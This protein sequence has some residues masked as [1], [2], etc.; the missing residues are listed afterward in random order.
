MLSSC[1]KRLVKSQNQCSLWPLLRM[2]ERMKFL[3][4]YINYIYIVFTYISC[5]FYFAFYCFTSKAMV[6]LDYWSFSFP[7]DPSKETWKRTWHWNCWNHQERATVT[8]MAHVRM[9][10]IH[11]FSICPNAVQVFAYAANFEVSYLAKNSGISK[12]MI[13]FFWMSNWKI[14]RFIFSS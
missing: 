2:V 3:H 5:R 11:G 7:S 4:I 10:V 14:G 6:Y 13:K 12:K 8:S 1:I 9:W